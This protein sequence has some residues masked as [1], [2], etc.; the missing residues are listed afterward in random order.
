MAD[1]L[2][3][4]SAAPASLV[5]TAIN[6]T[7]NGERVLPLF[8]TRHPGEYFHVACTPTRQMVW[9]PPGRAHE[10]ARR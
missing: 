10:A 1:V 7:R 8:R 9:K 3:I 2:D 4:E 5:S 6:L